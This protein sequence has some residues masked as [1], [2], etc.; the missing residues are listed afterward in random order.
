MSRLTTSVAVLLTLAS[1]VACSDNTSSGPDGGADAAIVP[2]TSDKACQATKQVC[3]PLNKRCVDCLFDAHC[4]TGER[5]QAFSCQTY[6]H[7]TNSLDC[8]AAAGK[9]ICSKV[10]GAC[11]AC[12]DT[13]DCGADQECVDNGCVAFSPCKNSKEGVDRAGSIKSRQ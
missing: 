9:P 11:V 13:A 4:D 1:F 3:D 8:K 2:C 6:T 5:C 7:C 10:L 12:V